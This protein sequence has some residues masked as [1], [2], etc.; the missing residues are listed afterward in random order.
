MSSGVSTQIRDDDDDD[1]DDDTDLGW[2]YNRFAIVV[3]VNGA[4]RKCVA[5]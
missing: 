2:S 1:D 5:L 4:T 3:L